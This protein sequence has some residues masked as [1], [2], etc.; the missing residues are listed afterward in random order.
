MTFYESTDVESDIRYIQAF[1]KF[2]GKI[3]E[4]QSIADRAIEKLCQNDNI[5]KRRQVFVLF[6]GT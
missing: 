1:F 6:Y 2:I 5:F 3:A 4:T